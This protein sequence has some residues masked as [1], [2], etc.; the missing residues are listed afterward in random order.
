MDTKYQ[1]R[2]VKNI[3]NPICTHGSYNGHDPTLSSVFPP[4]FR[5]WAFVRNFGLM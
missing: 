2:L 5:G 1:Q 4:M 3:F